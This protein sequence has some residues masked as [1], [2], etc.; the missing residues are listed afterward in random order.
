MSYKLAINT[1]FAVNRYPLAEEWIDL[2]ANK[3]EV[4]YVQ[5]TSDLLNPYLPEKIY[6]KEAE[7]I[8]KLIS[9]NDLII[10]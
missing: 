3:L 6:F 8:Q 7:N 10:N 5:F 2:V 9:K 4:K 1:G